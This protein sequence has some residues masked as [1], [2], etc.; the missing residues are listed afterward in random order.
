M[1]TDETLEFSHIGGRGKLH[2]QA[3]KASINLVTEMGVPPIL[4][5]RWG[6]DLFEVFS[7]LVIRR[8]NLS[9]LF[10]PKDLGS[11]LN[12]LLITKVSDAVLQILGVH[13]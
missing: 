9:R 7:R 8:N 12:P 11:S 6:S 10:N 2:P 3:M 13:T 1:M 5:G 4:S